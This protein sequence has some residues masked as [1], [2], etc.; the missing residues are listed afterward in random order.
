[1]T[2]LIFVSAST[3]SCGE[4]GY[5]VYYRVRYNGKDINWSWTEDMFCEAPIKSWEYEAEEYVQE[6]IDDKESKS[7]Q[8]CVNT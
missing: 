5:N 2:V 8:D 7:K 4:R 6:T 3:N 1:M